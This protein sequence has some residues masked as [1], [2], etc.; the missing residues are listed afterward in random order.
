MKRFA[1]RLSVGET[2]NIFG[3][4]Q[5][6]SFYGGEKMNPETLKYFEFDLAYL[7]LL[8]Q[9]GLKPLSRWEKPVPAGLEA[10]LD[11]LGFES[12]Y[13]R[14]RL[15]NG[16]TT[17]EFIFSR[18]DAYIDL[19]LH[20][21]DDI[22]IDKSVNTQR[23]EGFLFGFPPCCVESFA[24]HGYR[25]NGLDRM[26]QKLLFHWACPDCKLTPLLV[27]EYRRVYRQ[28]KE[29]LAG[30]S[31]AST[32]FA[33]TGKQIGKKVVAVAASVALAAMS[34]APILPANALA[35]PDWNGDPHWLPLAKSDDADQDLLMDIEE[36]FLGLQPENPDSDSDGRIDG[37]Q[38][39][40]AMHL[41]CSA[42][43]HE[44]TA[45]RPYLIDHML[46]GNENCTVCDSSVNMGYCELVNPLEKLIIELPYISL[47]YLQH[48]SFRYAGSLHGEGRVNPRQLKAVLEADGTWHRLKLAAGDRDEDGLYNN[49]EPHLGTDPALADTD[50]N[51]IVDG[52]QL[53]RAFVA[54]IDSLPRGLR[55]DSVYVEEHQAKG[56]ESCARCGES[57]NM[58]YLRIVNPLEGQWTEL[59]FL[60]LH[61]MHCGGFA[62]DGEVHKGLASARVLAMVLDPQGAK[63]VLKTADDMDTDGLNAAEESFFATDPKVPDSNDNGLLD[64][65][66]LGL[67]LAAEIDSLPR[68]AQIAMPYMLEHLVWGVETCEVCGQTVNMGYT[69]IINPVSGD[70]LTTPVI[71]LHAMNHGSFTYHGNLHDGRIDPIKLAQVLAVNPTAVPSDA[72]VPPSDLALWPNYPNPFNA[73]TVIRFELP[74]PGWVT[75]EIHNLLGQEVRTLVSDNSPAGAFTVQWDGKDEGGKDLVSGVYFCRMRAGQLVAVKRMALLR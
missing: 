46:R 58:G 15:Q 48:G 7:A 57:V 75:L 32:L 11:D 40:Q 12:A 68:E 65:I 22:P 35:A 67:Q 31:H 42:L 1:S 25:P 38:L 72:N 50:Q 74:R 66:E 2:V 6:L 8:T 39:A 36:P 52:T 64:G 37:V 45:D 62:Y 5:T 26:E 10:A 69:E 44:V 9:N 54:V 56:V 4:N 13:V 19:Y 29:L 59:P 70:T 16:G 30:Q 24:R 3:Q 23:F 14:R 51:G 61:Y 43:P 63:H 71:G 18:S 53:A 17:T 49:D 60:A 33:E 27:P 55:T 21:F 34:V 73:A 28:C 41:I 47:H 20:R